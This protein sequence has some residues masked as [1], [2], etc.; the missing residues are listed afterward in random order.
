M[1]QPPLQR[2]PVALLAVTVACRSCGALTNA[3]A[4]LLAPG[5]W[6]TVEREDAKRLCAAMLTETVRAACLVGAIGPRRSEIAARSYWANG[7]V[8]CNAIV[9]DFDVFAEALPE[10][11]RE[12]VDALV[13]LARTRL[14]LGDWERLRANAHVPRFSPPAGDLAGLDP[15]ELD[16]EEVAVTSSQRH[17]RLVDGPSR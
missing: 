6:I 12:G 13:P 17:L 3:A 4:A 16:A 5:T 9:E 15:D 1:Q 11:L 14:P 8:F 10:V 2:V 7:C